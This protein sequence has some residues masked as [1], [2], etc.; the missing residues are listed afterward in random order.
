M[1]KTL[2]IILLACFCGITAGR[3]QFYS[4]K[5]NAALLAVGTVNAG[6]E[7]SLGKQWSLDIS[8]YWNPI[9]TDRFSARAWY[10]QPGVRYWLFEHFVGHFF[11]SHLAA[12]KYNVG[13]NRW[14]YKG[15][16]AGIGFS[17]GYT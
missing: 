9:K 14:Y 7:L 1:R 15:R 11:A 16:F 4:V 8:G 10:I 5:T 13:N 3:A 6:T 17:Y 12:G 2:I